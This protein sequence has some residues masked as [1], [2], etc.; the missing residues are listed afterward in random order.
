LYTGFISKF[1]SGGVR[2]W[3][4]F[5]GGTPSVGANDGVGSVVTD[6]SGNL[7]LCGG[8][9]TNN[10]PVSAGAFQIVQR[11]GTD[12]FVAKFDSTGNRIWATLYGGTDVD[13]PS[14]IDVDTRGNPVIVGTTQ[15]P[16]LTTTAGAFQ[17]AIGG[18]T[19]MFVARFNGATGAH[20]WGTY[21]GGTTWEYMGEVAVD[22]RNHVW[23][24]GYSGSANFHVTADAFQSTIQDQ[25]GAPTADGAI[26]RFDTLGMPAWSTFFGGNG[27]DMIDGLDVNEYGCTISGTTFSA[28]LPVTAGAHGRRHA[29]RHDP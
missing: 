7:L 17:Q 3:N 5:L 12:A 28:T 1:S 18:G 16:D 26:V 9:L 23:I 22:R 11:G 29:E 27:F 20:M 6:S 13:C 14:S 2:I 19:D 25:A 8:V 24:A 4:T 21:Y 10:F 15:S